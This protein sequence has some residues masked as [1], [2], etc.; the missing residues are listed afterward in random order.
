MLNP[1]GDS[2]RPMYISKLQ[3]LKSSENTRATSVYSEDNT[4][5]RFGLH[6]VQIL[7]IYI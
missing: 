2:N 5:R 7:L 3:D 1:L 4:G 6:V